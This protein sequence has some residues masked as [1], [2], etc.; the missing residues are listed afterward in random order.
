MTGT[1]APAEAADLIHLLTSQL[2]VTQSQAEGGSGAIFQAAK[3]N[4]SAEDFS[5]VAKAVPGIDKMMDA[6]P[7]AKKA[8]DA[9]GGVSSLLG[10]GSGKLGTMANLASSFQQ[11]GLSGDMVGRF[12]PIILNYVK[13]N[14]G[15]YAME[16]L[17]GALL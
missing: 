10:N 16:L 4:L 3:Q 11:L 15:K 1:P 8:S 14:G 5:T 17:K 6:A 12:T 9:L 2:G 13:Q 7:K